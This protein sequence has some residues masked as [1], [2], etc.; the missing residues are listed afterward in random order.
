MPWDD[1][2]LAIGCVVIGAISGATVRYRNDTLGAKLEQRAAVI[3]LI[4]LVTAVILAVTSNIAALSSIPWSAWIAAIFPCP[5]GL[6]VSYYSARSIFKMSIQDARTVATEV[7]ECNIGVAYAILLL[8]YKGNDRDI[9]L[10]FSGIVAYTVFNEIYIFAAAFYWRI[11][12][13]NTGSVDPHSQQ[14]MDCDCKE[15]DMPTKPDRDELLE[16]ENTPPKSSSA[17]EQYQDLER[18]TDPNKENSVDFISHDKQISDI[19]HDILPSHSGEEEYYA[20][21]RPPTYHSPQHRRSP[22]S[23]SNENNSM[24]IVQPPSPPVNFSNKDDD[25]CVLSSH[26]HSSCHQYNE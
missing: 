18:A 15:N 19:F 11:I 5:I 25:E 4:L 17:N 10:A 16:N 26:S 1:I 21:P 12:D 20:L 2:S 23:K 24:V 6:A 3:G 13:P 22:I 7:G 14:A 9:R 8:L